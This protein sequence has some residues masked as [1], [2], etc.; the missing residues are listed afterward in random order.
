MSKLLTGGLYCGIL[1]F[2]AVVFAHLIASELDNVPCTTFSDF[3]NMPNTMRPSAPR[4]QTF[5]TI[6]PTATPNTQVPRMMASQRMRKCF[7]PCDR[8]SARFVFLLPTDINCFNCFFI[9][10]FFNLI[11]SPQQPRP[12]A[13]APLEPQPPRPQCA[14]CPSTST[15]PACATPSSTWRLSHRSPCSR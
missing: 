15:L 6:R 13:S 8:R 12:S 3:Q 10:L 7:S 1:C 2:L 14:P 4:P 5:N 9:Y 11:S